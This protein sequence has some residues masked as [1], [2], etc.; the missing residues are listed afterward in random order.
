M[1]LKELKQL[2]RDVLSLAH[3]MRAI[4]SRKAKIEVQRSKNAA[5]PLPPWGLAGG[6][7]LGGPNDPEIRRLWD[8]AAQEDVRLLKLRND[9][10][11]ELDRLWRRL[12]TKAQLL[13]DKA[14]DLRYAPAPLR[15]LVQDEPVFVDL[16]RAAQ[17][18]LKTNPPRP[19]NVVRPPD[20]AWLKAN[21]VKHWKVARQLALGAGEYV[22]TAQLKARAHVHQD[23][24]TG[25]LDDL[26]TWRWSKND[27]PRGEHRALDT[28]IRLA[29]KHE[30]DVGPLQPNP[31]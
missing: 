16:E 23:S 30:T 10:N 15:S 31:D 9:L 25:I 4:W 11:P 19:G 6:S 1:S 13:H 21:K 5:T 26:V 2:A 17:Y 22:T 27:G 18:L 20:W 29:N 3:G 8:A 28:L 24:L 12:C 7:L 14:I